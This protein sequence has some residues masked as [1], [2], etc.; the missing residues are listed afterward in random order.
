MGSER[1]RWAHALYRDHERHSCTRLASEPT[2]CWPYLWPKK[3]S[4][5]SVKNI[6]NEGGCRD[7][8]VP[9]NTRR[10]CEED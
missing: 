4:G 8:T 9:K 10:D 7:D 2:V 1:G 5:K 3:M 6:K